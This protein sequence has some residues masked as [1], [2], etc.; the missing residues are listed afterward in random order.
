MREMAKWLLVLAA[1]VPGRALATSADAQ[2]L[3][4]PVLFS[5]VWHRLV[6]HFAFARPFNVEVD[7]GPL[8]A[9]VA[10]QHRGPRC[11]S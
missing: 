1:I 10:D 7:F 2:T 8:K 6:L 4:W 11:K 9:Q 5:V 3:Q